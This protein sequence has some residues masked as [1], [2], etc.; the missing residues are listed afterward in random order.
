MTDME[1]EVI[2]HLMKT[3]DGLSMM[4]CRTVITRL[5]S[6]VVRKMLSLGIKFDKDTKTFGTLQ[7]A[8]NIYLV[9][10]VNVEAKPLP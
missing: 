1:S 5:R 8:L 7:Q 4:G 9:S 3:I 10:P 6:D 2:N